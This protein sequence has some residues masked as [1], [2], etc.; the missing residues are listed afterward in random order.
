[1]QEL[2]DISARIIGYCY[3]EKYSELVCTLIPSKKGLKLGFFKGADLPDP[4]KLLQGK[5]KIS[6]YVEIS[7]QEDIK[8]DSLTELLKEAFK[9]YRTPSNKGLKIS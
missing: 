8:T 1:M 4:E 7:T 6:R 5:G 2:L 3:G 9:A